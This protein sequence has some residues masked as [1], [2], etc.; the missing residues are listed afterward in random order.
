MP[1]SNHN[2][3]SPNPNRRSSES[4]N[5]M[6]RSFTGNPFSKPSSLVANP[7]SSFSHTPANSPIDFPRKSFDYEKENVKDQVL[8]PGKI[9]SPSPAATSKS[10]KNFMSPTISASFKVA[11]SPR[12]KIL[13]ERNETALSSEHKVHVRKVTFAD[14]LEQKRLDAS[15]DGS[16]NH[17]PSFESDDNIS[18]NLSVSDAGSLIPKDDLLFENV[19]MNSPLISQN[20]TQIHTNSLFEN[21]TIEPLIPTN[22][23]HTFENVSVEPLIPQN[24]IRTESSFENVSIEPDFVN[25]D[26]TFKLSPPAATPPVSYT[27]TVVDPLDAD[28]SLPPY[29]HK[30][31]YLSPRPQFLH[32]RPKPKM[33][34][35]DRFIMS[36]SFSDSEVTED[37]QSEE[38]LK[39]SEDVSS[40]ETVKQ[41]EE[42]ISEPSPVRTLLPEETVE[43]KELPKSRFSLRSMAVAL[44]LLL[45]I[46][47]VSISVTNSPGIDHAVFGEFYEAYKLSELSEFARANFD[48]FAQFSKANYEGLARNLHIWFTKSL[49]SITEL[50]SDVR[51]ARSLAQLQYFNLT[52]LNDYTV[53][54]QYPTCGCHENEIGIIHPIAQEQPVASEI[55]VDAVSAEHYDVYEEQLH[56]DI[57]MVTGFENALDA[58]ESEEVHKGQSATIFESEEQALQLSKVDVQNDVEDVSNS[59]EALK[60]QSVTLVEPE[61]TLQLVEAAK[62][63]SQTPSDAELALVGDVEDAAESEAFKSVTVVELER[64]LEMEKIQTPRDVDGDSEYSPNSNSEAAE[65]HDKEVFGKGSV[66]TRLAQESVANL[67]HSPVSDAEIQTENKEVGDSASTD[68]AAI[69]RNEQILEASQIPQNMGLYL[70]LCAGTVI[71]AG[72]TFNWSR[73][74]KNSSKPKIESDNNQIS[75]GK[76]SLRSAPVE[77]EVVGESSPSEMVGESC[78]SEMSSFEKSS[79]YR[80]SQLN[81]TTSIDKKRRNNH[82]RESLVSSDSMGDSMGSPSYGSLTV[83]EKIPRGRGDDEIVTPVRRSSRIRSLATSPV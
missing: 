15:I 59:E 27:H 44:I 18:E 14:P 35:E 62:E 45:S 8:K 3:K 2:T 23:V 33:E 80:V 65:I 74:V 30:T 42:L 71:I 29:D 24:E 60:D 50:I 79:S 48:Q 43:A 31:N 56:H 83:F 82:R 38:S 4:N 9:R 55:A 47:F 76:P 63:E 54:N 37:T 12:R 73:K 32:Y 46:A 16:E 77:T 11:E 52:M 5:H 68:A 1:S 28:P 69:R 41:E 17:F 39:E 70:L 21:V 20:E 10:S 61:Q 57:E 40:D 7:R 53:V 26:P 58:P 22:E 19:P 25:L 34:L 66:D 51:G 6:R 67:K 72:A 81:E 49:S 13:S 75:P 64:A 36:S 78:P